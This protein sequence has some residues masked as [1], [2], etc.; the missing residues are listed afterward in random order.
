M[1]EKDAATES[2][3]SQVRE[4]KG[5]RVELD[6][7]EQTLLLNVSDADEFWPGQFTSFDDP[8]PSLAPSLSGL[9]DKS[10][11][12]AAMLA[13][14]AKQVDDRIYASVEMAAQKGAGKFAGKVNFL[15]TVFQSQLQLP[16]HIYA[17]ALLGGIDVPIPT[18][19]AKE[20]EQVKDQFLA[21]ELKSKPIGFYCWNQALKRIFQQDRLL[22]EPINL[23]HEL[24]SCTAAISSMQDAMQTYNSYLNM[25]CRLTNS[26][27]PGVHGLSELIEEPATV[28][29][30]LGKEY[31][32]FPPSQAHETELIKKLFGTTLIPDGF[33]LA[34]EMVNRIQS[35]KLSLRPDNQSG[36]YDF[37]T[38]SLEPLV[39]PELTQEGQR[40]SF[41]KNYLDLLVQLFKSALTLT[42]ETHIKQ[43]ESPLAGCKGIWDR[44]PVVELYVNPELSVEPTY[45][46]Y[47]RCALGYQFLISVLK[48]CFGENGINSIPTINSAGTQE[49]NLA[50]TINEMRDLFFGAAATVAKEV[51]GLSVRR[52]FDAL[53]GLCNA[54]QN[55]IEVENAN[56]DEQVCRESF[57]QWVAGEED[58]DVYSDSRVMVPVFFDEERGKTKAWLF[59]G[60][61]SR[62]LD[63]TYDQ[64]PL[65]KVFDSKNKPAGSNV[66][67]IFSPTRKTLPYPVM[68]EVYFDRLM[69]RE[70]FRAHCDKY[71]TRTAILENL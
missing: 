5:Y 43:L 61:L 66:K 32:F 67:V 35:G 10:F 42:R 17:A 52:S 64:Q 3:Y 50:A 6:T 12:S 11:V 40:L 38:W 4:I 69:D 23:P 41:G 14:K 1:S 47:L 36:W 44:D 68:E 59:L 24:E 19:R 29:S 46:F 30:Q 45:T 18:S 62:T 33:S 21:N 57:S 2:G 28:Q 53:I 55:G 51:G 60:W 63:V 25:M 58:A 48:E 22:Q 70:E 54:L 20:I 49:N 16:V 15:N 26:F 56:I 71:K 13:Q 65:A 9:V 34:D 37:Q 39:A 8:E 31:R 7:S 27:P